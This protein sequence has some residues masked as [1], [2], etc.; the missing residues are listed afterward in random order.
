MQ[1]PKSISYLL[2]NFFAQTGKISFHVTTEEPV[3]LYMI[4]ICNWEKY[5]SEYQRQKVYQK[6]Y[7]RKN[8]KLSKKLSR[9]RRSNYLQEGEGEVEG[10][11]EEQEETRRRKTSSTADAA[12]I[13]AFLAIGHKPF[14]EPRFQEIWTANY[15]SAG[16]DPIWTDI[17]EATIQQCKRRGVEV[18]GLF[19]KHKHK[20]E[21]EDVKRR[22]KRTPL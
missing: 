16:A 18:P 14:G 19:Y 17:M 13:E 3:R 12:I 6:T 8:K 20:V 15:S 4:T 7:R 10:E 21:E 5:Q 2:L 22:Y 9:K 1:E 11:K